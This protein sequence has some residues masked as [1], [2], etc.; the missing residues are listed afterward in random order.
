MNKLLHVFGLTG[1][2]ATGKST[3]AALM[4]Q[5]YPNIVVFNA[6]ACV[7]DLYRDVDVLRQLEQRFGD[8]VLKRGEVDKA[9]LRQ[10][11]FSNEADKRFLESIF[12]PRVR[13]EC[14]ALLSEATKRNGSRLFVADVPLLFEGGFDFGQ[15]AN[16]LVATSRE[17]QIDRL[18]NRND[19]QDGVV[20]AVI[21]SQIDIE[22][23]LSLADIVFWNEG[24][25]AM[26]HKQCSR[27]LRSLGLSV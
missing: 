24:S 14:L 25:E 23:K 2:I 13:E 4:R 22:A 27:F 10:R 3:C 5:L 7:A 18:K 19:W 6:D 16:L 17:T 21:A 15:S 26:L 9:Y 20:E 12:H 8:L 1:G 11:I